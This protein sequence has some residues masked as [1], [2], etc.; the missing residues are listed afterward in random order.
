[1]SPVARRSVLLGIAGLVLLPAP[2][3]AFGES[4]SFS[5]RL[6]AA[7]KRQDLGRRVSGLSRWAFELVQRTSA[8]G[9]LV[10][11]TVEADRPAL[12]A[13]P[14]AVWAGDTDVGALSLTQIRGLERFLKLGGVLVVDDSAPESGAFSRSVRRELLRVL[15]ATPPVRLDPSHVIYRTFYL[16]DRPVG[17]VLG[18]AHIEAIVRGRNAQVFF[19]A[20]DLLGALARGDEGWAFEVAPGGPEQR[21]RAVR[22]AVNIAMYVLCSD[23]KDDQVHASWLMR[24]RGQVRP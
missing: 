6:L 24:R 15:P 3:L 8:P 19:L 20:H 2:V 4:G 10:A 9:K 1:M 14:F 5:A 7:G 23:Y 18:P 13:E 12:L 17:R 21:E 11:V 22:L 16:L